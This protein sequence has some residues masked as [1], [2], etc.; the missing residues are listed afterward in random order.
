[1]TTITKDEFQGLE[2]ITVENEQISFSLLPQLGGK[3]I[4]LI[5]RGEY[6]CLKPQAER[7]WALAITIGRSEQKITG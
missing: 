3:M 7:T 2:R 5:Q 6:A 4:S 1:M